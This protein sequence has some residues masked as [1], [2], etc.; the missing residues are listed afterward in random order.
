M[1]LQNDTKTG[2]AHG[3]WYGDACGTAF[4]LEVLGERWSMLIVR[5]LLVGPRRFS[6][7]RASLPGI[8]AKVLTERLE[9]LANWGVLERK[10]LPPPAAARIYELTPWGYSA[11]PAIMELGRWAARSVRHDPNLPLSAA[12]LM[13]SMK[14]MQ[15]PELRDAPDMA[16]G[17]VVGGEPYRV[18]VDGG[19]LSAVRGEIEDCEAVMRC[20]TARTIAGALYA[21]IPLA[22][23]EAEAGLT[24]EGDRAVLERFVTLFGLPPKIDAPASA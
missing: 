20:D 9:G 17:M 23:L 14:T 3:K 22:A 4:G 21:D 7:L 18:S 12:S 5:E 10:S 19:K 16:V 2:P 13:T 1:K 8:S 24:V 15:L 11:E 6:D